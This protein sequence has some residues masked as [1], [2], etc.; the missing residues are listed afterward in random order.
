MDRVGCQSELAL[1]NILN[2]QLVSTDNR[3]VP[4]ARSEVTMTSNLSTVIEIRSK[5]EIL[6]NKVLLKSGK[7]KNLYLE[8][9][10]IKEWY[11]DTIR[12][13]NQITIDW[14]YAYE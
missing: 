13:I 10:N 8:L 2:E 12:T 1:E 5:A 7:I 3:W 6:R 9:I 11:K 4:D 14:K